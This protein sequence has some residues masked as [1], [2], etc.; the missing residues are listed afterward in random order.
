MTTHLRTLGS[1]CAAA[2]LLAATSCGWKSDG[3]ERLEELY[4][5]PVVPPDAGPPPDPCPMPDDPAATAVET[6][7]DCS[8]GL[9]GGRWA[10]RMVQFG[11]MSPAGTPWRITLADHFLAQASADGKDLELTFCAQSSSLT[12]SDGSPVSLGITSMPDKTRK[13]IGSHALPL[14][15]SDGGLA[16]GE[17]AWL[18]GVKD[19]AN[20]LADALP[21]DKADPHVWDEDEDG[22]PGVTVDVVNPT[23]QRY[24]ARRSKWSFGQTSVTKEWAT[25]TLSFA[26][27]ENALDAT[28]ALLKTVAPISVR[29]ECKSLYQ[30]R[31]VDA[32]YTCDQVMAS[33]KALWRDAPPASQP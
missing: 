25:G 14:P 2:A 11:S 30:M 17:R 23:G 13:A 8:A 12:K 19:L 28:N 6:G 26:V 29:S 7:G 21:T 27:T 1:V 5:T 31:C 18:W 20:P 4:P 16:S 24:M 32:A 15:L 33:A 22:H 9:A 3:L 10:V